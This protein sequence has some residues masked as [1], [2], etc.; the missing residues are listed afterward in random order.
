MLEGWR[1]RILLVTAVVGYE[2]CAVF[3]LLVTAPPLP[4]DLAIYVDA[5]KRARAGVDLYRPF[6]IGLSFVYPPA[7]LVLLA[8]FALLP[9]AAIPVTWMAFNVALYILAVWLLWN[10]VKDSSSPAIDRDSTRAGPARMSLPMVVLFAAVLYAPFLE[11][12]IVGQT[13]VMV[14]AGLVLFLTRDRWSRRWTGDAGIAAA[15]AL[16]MSP[17]LLVGSPI[18]DRNWREVARI[19]AAALAIAG[20]SIV[21][22]GWA[23]W[24][25]FGSVLPALALGDRSWA[26]QSVQATIARLAR[27]GGASPVVALLLAV[28]STAVWIAWWLWTLARTRTAARIDRELFG[29]C[30][31]VVATPLVW[32]HTLTLLLPPIVVLLARANWDQLLPARENQSARR[33]RGGKAIGRSTVW[34]ALCGVALI[35]TDRIWEVMLAVPPIAATAGTLAVLWAAWR[36]VVS[37][38]VEAVHATR[39]PGLG[40]T[41]GP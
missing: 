10:D 38:P 1:R 31:I 8:P 28:S 21:L 32:Y 18:V 39:G 37:P 40:D 4:D 11:G 3:T 34:A 41:P 16:K 19:G 35:Q 29:I 25:D 14:L 20:A 17:V 22:F 6:H 24:R 30:I 2:A 26:N 7:A 23:P 5:L 36:G 13:N 15:I 27:A 12:L 33:A 9:R